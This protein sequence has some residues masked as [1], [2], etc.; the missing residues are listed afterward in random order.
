MNFIYTILFVSLLAVGL[1][2]LAYRIYSQTQMETRN[3]IENNEFNDKVKT[4]KSNLLFFYTDWCNHCQNSKPIWENVK[5]DSKFHQFNLNFVDING[6]DEKNR[7]LLKTYNIKE[8]PTIILDHDD[9]KFIFDAKLETET[10]MKFLSFAY[11]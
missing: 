9:K 1:L 5:K 2:F 6:D 4:N 11:Q 3:Y 7:K 8:Y 10:L